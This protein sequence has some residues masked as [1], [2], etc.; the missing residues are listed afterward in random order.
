MAIARKSHPASSKSNSQLTPKMQQVLAS[1]ALEGIIVTA[2]SLRDIQLL[3]SGKMSK[4][5]FL[6]KTLAIAKS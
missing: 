6:K 4:E 1:L 3:D 5:E 2:E